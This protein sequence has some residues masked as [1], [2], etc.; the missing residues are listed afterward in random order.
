MTSLGSC[1]LDSSSHDHLESLTAE[2]LDQLQSEQMSLDHY[3]STVMTSVAP[4]LPAYLSRQLSWTTPQGGSE[5]TTG[6]STAGGVAVCVQVM[7]AVVKLMETKKWRT[8]SSEPLNEVC[9]YS[10]HA[11]HSCL[12]HCAHMGGFLPSIPLPHCCFL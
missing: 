1:D 7:T 12:T 4:L 11:V 5:V 6:W 9:H 10:L 3:C 2:I 8:R